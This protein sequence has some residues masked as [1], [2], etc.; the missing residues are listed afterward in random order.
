MSENDEVVSNS[1]DFNAEVHMCLD[2][3]LLG[4]V[5]CGL[6]MDVVL[7]TLENNTADSCPN[8]NCYYLH[9]GRGYR[10]LNHAL[11]GIASL[12]SERLSKPG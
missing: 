9:S 6:V 2:K 11:R 5:S 10:G 3:T 4:S 12:H 8:R 7:V 1:V